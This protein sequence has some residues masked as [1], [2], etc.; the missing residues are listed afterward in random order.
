MVG[1]QFARREVARGVGERFLLT[2]FARENR[3][4]PTRSEVDGAVYRTPEAWA[5]DARRQ[6]WL[7]L[8][9]GVRFVRLDAKLVERDLRAAVAT[10]RAAL[11]PF[12]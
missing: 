7:E 9:Y 5:Y 2:K 1:I 3:K 12:D 11:P 10:I 4:R 6:A 8:V